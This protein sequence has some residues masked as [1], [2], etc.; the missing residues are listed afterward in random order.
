MHT[1]FYSEVLKGRNC[2]GDL[3]EGGR[4]MDDI[5]DLR[6]TGCE[7]VDGFQFS[8]YG[9][10]VVFCEHSKEPSCSIKA[11]ILLTS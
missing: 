10:M 7:D 1:E 2:L 8:G 5:R 3:Y 4:M 9:P 11:S 6:V